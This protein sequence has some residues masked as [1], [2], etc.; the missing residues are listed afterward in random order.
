[1]K[2]SSAKSKARWLQKWTRDLLLSLAPWLHKDDIRSTAMGQSGEDLQFSP[3]AREVFH[4]S[5]ECKN[6]EALNWWASYDQAK[7]NCPVGCEPIVVAKK[8]RRKPVVM[9][10]A[11]YFF[12]NCS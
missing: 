3:A 7:A 1:M 8:N 2:T 5:I 11:E 12:K 10:D 4:L 6:V 9:I